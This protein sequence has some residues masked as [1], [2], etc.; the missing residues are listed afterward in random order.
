MMNRRSSHHWL[1]CSAV[2]ALLPLAGPPALAGGDGT[3]RLSVGTAAQQGDGHSLRGG[4]SASARYVSF[5][6]T[7]TNLV[8]NDA[9]GSLRDILLLDRSSGALQ[10]I[11]VS[12]AGIQANDASENSFI[13]RNGN[14]IAFTSGA[15]NLVGGD[16]NGR[17]DVFLRDVAAGTTIRVSVGQE[18][19]EGNGDSI[20]GGLSGNS[21]FI[22]F[23]SRATNLVPGDT[24]SSED[25]FVHDRVQETTVRASVGENGVQADQP[26]FTAF[27]SARLDGVPRSTS[28]PGVISS[29]GRF[30]AFHSRATNLVSMNTNA[31]SQ[32]Y[33]RDL[34]QETTTL[35]S[36]ADDGTP[37]N[38]ASAQALVSDDGRYVVFQSDATNLVASD[39][40][41]T[42]DVFLRDRVNGT[43]TRISRAADGG[44]ANGCSF[45]GAMSS[46]G[47]HIVYGSL[48]TNIVEAD[49][50][51][52]NDL[53]VFDQETGRTRRLVSVNGEEPN[54]ASNFPAMTPGGSL[55]LFSS[56]ASNLVPGDSNERADIFLTD[57]HH[58]RTAATSGRL[59]AAA[60]SNGR[61]DGPNAA[62][63]KLDDLIEPEN[64]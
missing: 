29:D 5:T 59:R 23:R 6:T 32:I 4:L 14:F 26:S 42:C 17:A 34:Q 3:K 15:S 7:A 35:I 48:A 52:T 54:K 25:V 38:K 22:V 36:V 61:D 43:T 41:N 12:S 13:S 9:N 56:D 1:A 8:P 58:S 24:N 50:N 11:S 57:Q 28:L 45:T 19:G 37:G 40:N 21:R 63:R 46:N 64:P 47:R 62:G 39:T 20:G 2:L 18:G 55:I 16:T 33:L 10:R 53:F 31:V 30:L 51:S 49:M 60:A 27:T 44:E